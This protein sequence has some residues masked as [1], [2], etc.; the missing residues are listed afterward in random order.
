MLMG[1]GSAPSNNKPNRWLQ[2]RHKYNRL[3][4]IKIKQLINLK[5]K[6]VINIEAGKSAHFNCLSD[7]R[8]PPDIKNLQM[9]CELGLR[10]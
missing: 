10:T 1:S 7:L 6:L 3:I 5:F 8:L 4:E 2:R 9:L